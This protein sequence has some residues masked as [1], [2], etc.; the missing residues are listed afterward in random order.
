MNIKISPSGWRT[1]MSAKLMPGKKLE[2]KIIITNTVHM[3]D[4]ME[5]VAM[6]V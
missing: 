4:E 1:C 2:E 6:Q 5:C 3:T